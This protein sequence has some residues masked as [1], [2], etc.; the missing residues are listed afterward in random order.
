MNLDIRRR[1]IKTLGFFIYCNPRVLGRGSG[2][3]SLVVDLKRGEY[4]NFLFREIFCFFL[5]RFSARILKNKE[6]NTIWKN[7]SVNVI[8]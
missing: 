1:E 2:D 3:R 6:K 5:F 7:S 8:V 4:L